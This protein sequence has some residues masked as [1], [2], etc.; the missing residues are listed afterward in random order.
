MARDAKLHHKVKERG[1]TCS[2]WQVKNV[3]FTMGIQW[4]TEFEQKVGNEVLVV[5]LWLHKR[6]SC[7]SEGD[8]IEDS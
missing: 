7:A 3:S 1:A 6:A 5:A 4:F 8:F 2:A